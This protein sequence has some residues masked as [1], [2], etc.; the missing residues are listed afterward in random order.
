MTKP[1]DI[2]KQGTLHP[3]QAPMPFTRWGMDHTGP[4]RHNNQS[5]HLCTA[6]DHGTSYAMALLTKSPNSASCIEL[7]RQ[8]HLLF[9][10][11]QL[12][13]DNGQAFLSTEMSS[14]CKEK[15]IEQNFTKPYRPETNGKVERFNGIIKTIFYAISSINQSRSIQWVLDQSLSTYNRRPNL[16][17]YAPIYLALGITQEYSSSPYIRELTPTEE[18]AFASDI[19]KIYNPGTQYA[20]LNVANGKSARDEIRS[21]LQEKK[22]RLRVFG[23]GDWVLRQR[24]RNHKDEP[25]YDGPFVIAETNFNNGYILRTPGGVTLQNHYH[26]QQLFPAYVRDGHPVRSLWYGSKNLLE[27]DRRRTTD[28]LK[29]WDQIDKQMDSKKGE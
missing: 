4:I 21:Y 2:H 6:I 27:K 26:G 18:S 19:V 14:F 29:A 1:I 10:I 13:T 22:A 25:F 23:K 12:I 11:K 8:I 20:R 3:V 9:G 17:G 5:F 16:T 24:K 7:I 15:K 28:M